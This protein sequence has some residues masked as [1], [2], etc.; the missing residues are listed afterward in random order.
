M[1]RSEQFHITVTGPGNPRSPA[2]QSGVPAALCRALEL[3]GAEVHA[4]SEFGGGGMR[5]RLYWRAMG[6][7]PGASLLRGDLLVGIRSHGLER[8]LRETSGPVLMV[9]TELFVPRHRE[10]AVWLDQ[11]AVQRRDL[12]ALEGWSDR[13]V[14]Q[15]VKRQADACRSAVACF[16]ATEWCAESIAGDYGVAIDRIHVVG[17]APN[18]EPRAIDRDWTVPRFLFVASKW[19][20]KNGP[21]VLAAFARVRDRI[22]NAELTVAGHHPEINQPGVKTVGW[23]NL[24]SDGDRSL[25]TRLFETSTCL[26]IPS[27]SEAVGISAIEAGRAGVPS[28]GTINGGVRHTIGAGGSV[29]DPLDVDALTGQ[30]I[31]MCDPATAHELGALANAHTRDMTW[32]RIAIRVIDA[33]TVQS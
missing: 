21:R 25:L 27:L 2:T 33:L 24:A 10:I 17:R 5:A 18:V 30:M 28:I 4:N 15:T 32:E 26:L 20:R 11:T 31:R 8:R 3:L 22:P 23:L 14:G 13:A 6:T 1:P 29:V 9:Q 16:A 12:G 7:R 19:E